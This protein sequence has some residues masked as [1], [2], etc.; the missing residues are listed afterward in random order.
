MNKK[1]RVANEYDIVTSEC[2]EFCGKC[3][4]ISSIKG[5]TFPIVY[6]N[7]NGDRLWEHDKD[8][9]KNHNLLRTNFCKLNEVKENTACLWGRIDG[10]SDQF[11]STCGYSFNFIDGDCKE[12]EFFFCPKC[13]K[14]IK[15][16]SQELFND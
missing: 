16:Y 5:G 14:P 10:D 9:P 8:D 2:G 3:E 11:G 13:G 15:E 1:I 12:N 7:I 6:C 4:K